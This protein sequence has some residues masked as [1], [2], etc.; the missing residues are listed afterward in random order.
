MAAAESS[1][2]VEIPAGE[3]LILYRTDNSSYVDMKRADG[4]ICRL[5]VDL[6]RGWPQK[7]NGM[8]AEECFDGMMFAG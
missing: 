8:D 2:R 4:S 5:E 7:V 3:E 6:S 1:E